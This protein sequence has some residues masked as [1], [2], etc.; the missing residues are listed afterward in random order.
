V[1]KELEV[2]L[3]K[4][5][6]QK[7]PITKKYRRAKVVGLGDWFESGIIFLSL[8]QGERVATYISKKFFKSDKGCGCG[9]RKEKANTFGS[10]ILQHSRNILSLRWM[11]GAK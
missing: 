7:A 11:R 8:G 10:Q 6:V 2:P 9:G 3:T 1:T 4:T 5:K